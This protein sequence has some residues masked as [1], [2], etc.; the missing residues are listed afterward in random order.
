M[1]GLLDDGRQV[2]EDLVPEDGHHKVQVEQVDTNIGRLPVRAV[3]PG[4]ATS[5]SKK[6][7]AREHVKLREE[8]VDVLTK[9]KTSNF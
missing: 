5:G 8:G 1:F 3:F 2:V 4:E 9:N 7:A 6:L